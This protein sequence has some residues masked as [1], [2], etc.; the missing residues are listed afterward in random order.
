MSIRE[1]LGFTDSDLA[2]DLVGDYLTKHYIGDMSEAERRRAMHR[3][4]RLL[5]DDA[6]ALLGEAIDKMF[7]SPVLRQRFKAAI[8]MAKWENAM[9]RIVTEQSTVYLKPAVRR[10]DARNEE[11]QALIELTRH[12][13]RMHRLNQYA[14]AMNDA[15]IM[16]RVRDEGRRRIPVTD[17]ISSDDFYAVSHPNDPTWL[18]AIIIDQKAK[19]SGNNL[20]APRET[21]RWLVWTA[22][23]SFKM[24]DGGRVLGDTWQPNP[25]GRIPGILVHREPPDRAL[26][27]WTS[28]GDLV[29]A[30]EAAMF[31]SVLLMKE[32]KSSNR[33]AI[34]SGDLTNTATGQD[35][36]SET[37]MITGDGV[38]VQSIERGVNLSQYRDTADHI[39]ER[40]AAN[41]GIPPETLRQAG[42][43]SGFEIDLRRIPQ[44]ERR[45]RQVKVF[46]SVEREFAE[47]QSIV[48]SQDLPELAF[49]VEGWRID[50]AEVDRPM[51]ELD[52]YQLRKLK[53]SSGHSNVV[54]EAIEDNPDMNPE[55]A[56]M[57][58]TGNMRVQ[59]AFIEQM[60]ALNMPADADLSNPGQSPQDNGAMSQDGGDA[61]P[62]LQDGEVLQ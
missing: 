62:Q 38:S 6:D 51:S 32:A 5:F 42:A 13:E 35:A 48:L 39:I 7:Q 29:S 41:Y 22:D 49:G 36:D 3:R 45:N 14:N 60:R 28:G 34:F 40:T 43:A 11:Y 61:Q 47:I 44:E 26:L 8:P 1:Q 10:V 4:K 46:R 55:Q 30:T 59:A 56:L 52:R 2:W 16:F 53:R 25:F 24:T 15:F 19:K 27:D 20:F 9:K 23:E 18:I 50:F 58:V 57:F 54:Q 37:D 12:D 33:Q 31:L 17:V 21:E